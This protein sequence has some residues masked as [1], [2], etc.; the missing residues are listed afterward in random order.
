MKKTEICEVV[1]SDSAKS[2][3]YVIMFR[4]YISDME[5][6]KLNFP[7][8]YYSIFLFCEPSTVL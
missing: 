6:R 2:G 8:I 7:M 3:I 5:L 1:V 4:E